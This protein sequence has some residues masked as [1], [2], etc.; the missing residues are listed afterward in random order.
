ML[1]HKGTKELCTERL[2]LRKFRL[3]DAENM[4][5]NYASDERVTQFMP[6]KPYQS[7]KEVEAFVNDVIKD[8]TR[9]DFYH[10]AIEIHH[11]MIGSISTVSIDDRHCNCEVGYCIGYN[12]WGKGIMSEALSKVL[13]FLFDEV[14]V[15]RITAKHDVENPASGKVMKKCNMTYEG[16]LREHYLR[17]DGTFSDA[18][19]YS[20]LKNEY[21][22]HS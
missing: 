8:Y 1:L 2:V 5:K 4:F 3:A 20:I 18:L 10:W 15:H 6:W 12:Y 17:H 19:V 13:A 22:H 21:R 11:E 16:R 9:Q 14:G 7:V